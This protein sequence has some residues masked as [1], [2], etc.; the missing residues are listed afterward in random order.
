MATAR[1]SA[2]TAAE[3]TAILLALK[4]VIATEHL[5]ASQSATQRIRFLKLIVD[6]LEGQG[7]PLELNELVL[8]AEAAIAASRGQKPTTH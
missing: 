5:D 3:K 2:F 7:P 1:L 4:R 8:L 6:R